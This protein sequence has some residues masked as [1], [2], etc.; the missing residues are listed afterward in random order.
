MSKDEYI[1][2]A[3]TTELAN[4]KFPMDD[5]YTTAQDTA[6]EIL[7]SIHDSYSPQARIVTLDKTSEDNGKICGITIADGNGTTLLNEEINPGIE[8]KHEY[9]EKNGLDL[10][11]IKTAK[12]FEERYGEIHKQL[13]RADEIWF[14]AHSDYLLFKQ[15]L[16]QLEKPENISKSKLLLAKI[17]DVGISMTKCCYSILNAFEMYKKPSVLTFFQAFSH[18]YNNR[19]QRYRRFNQVRKLFYDH[20]K[21]VEKYRKEKAELKEKMKKAKKIGSTAWK[22]AER[23]SVEY[24]SMTKQERRTE[25]ILSQVNKT[26]PLSQQKADRIKEYLLNAEPHNQTLKKMNIQQQKRRR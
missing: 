12:K 24:A 26:Y 21:E 8:I 3:A 7:Y 16:N 20:L 4:S 18:G 23:P 25:R 10:E 19:I 1:F 6:V 11:K 22:R 13:E 9:V 14:E 2:Q 17:Q 5:E 15:S